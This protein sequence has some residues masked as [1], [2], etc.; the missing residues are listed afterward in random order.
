M[1]TKLDNRSITNASKRFVFLLL[2][3]ATIYIPIKTSFSFQVVSRGYCHHVASSI[4]Q[5]GWIADD[6]EVIYK[7][8]CIQANFRHGDVAMGRRFMATTPPFDRSQQQYKLASSRSALQDVKLDGSTHS[9]I[10]LA[11]VNIPAMAEIIHQCLGLDRKKRALAKLLRNSPRLLNAF[12]SL[13]I[14]N[15]GQEWTILDN[16]RR[17]VG[18]KKSRFVHMLF[19]HPNLLA[20]VLT[21]NNLRVSAYFCL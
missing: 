6:D 19:R 17:L 8:K 16:L 1:K 3:Y 14:D 18:L 2:W 13:M 9:P 21:T 20:D 15:D 11:S 12:S 4:G 10:D 5:M 7:N